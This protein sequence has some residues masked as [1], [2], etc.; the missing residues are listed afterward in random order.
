MTNKTCPTCQ[1]E[2]DKLK[3]SLTDILIGVRRETIS[4][5]EIISICEKILDPKSIK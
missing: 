4:D 5:D 3:E 1:H 2:I